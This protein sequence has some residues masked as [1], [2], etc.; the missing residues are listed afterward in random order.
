MSAD[1]TTLDEKIGLIAQEENVPY[2]VFR[3]LIFAESSDQHFD[4]NGNVK[5]SSDGAMGYG[6]LMPKT[7]AML[8]VN[9]L[10]PMENLR[11][12][13]RY[14]KMQ[15]DRFDGNV[16]L[17]L[18]AYN[19]GPTITDEIGGVPNY[20]ETTGYISKILG[21]PEEQIPTVDVAAYR[22]GDY[23]PRPVLRPEEPQMA[24]MEQVEDPYAAEITQPIKYSAPERTTGIG[25]FEQFMPTDRESRTEVEEMSELGPYDL[26]EADERLYR[27]Y[28]G[29]QPMSFAQA[30]M[31]EEKAMK[32]GGIGPLN[33]VA[34]NMFLNRL[35]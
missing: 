19:A 18:S 30:A 16:M 17:A 32:G 24:A 20:K 14:F 9:P 7:A 25:A 2:D 4:K 3:R 26:R 27:K 8:G 1:Q 29:M 6:Q 33:Y 11:G 28:S 31:Q 15:L 10:D 35:E 21:I 23:S 13:A 22:A 12:A 34:R 5:R